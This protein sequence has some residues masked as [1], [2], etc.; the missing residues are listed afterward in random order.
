[1]S[2]KIL[3]NEGSKVKYSFA[4]K[5]GEGSAKIAAK[6]RKVLNQGGN[7]DYATMWKL[8]TDCCA[9]GSDTEIQNNTEVGTAAAKRFLA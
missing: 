2:N 8:S 6:R 9:A 3:E 7:N 5:D 4:R 1:M